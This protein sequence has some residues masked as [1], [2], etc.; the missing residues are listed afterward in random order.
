[1][2]HPKWVQGKRGVIRADIAVLFVGDEG[3]KQTLL[4][5]EPE[6]YLTAGGLREGAGSD[7]PAGAGAARAA[8]E[9][10]TDARRARASEELAHDLGRAARQTE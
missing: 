9:L 3:E 8:T 4:L 10:I 6:L 1:M 7:A 2:G 5:G